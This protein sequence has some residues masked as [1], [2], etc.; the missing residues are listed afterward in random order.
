[1]ESVWLWGGAKYCILLVDRATRKHALY[2][3]W[4]LNHEEIIRALDQYVLDMGSKPDCVVTDFENKILQGRVSAWFRQNGINLRAAP[5]GHQ[6]QNGLV[7]KAWQT[8]C[9]MAHAYITDM[10]MPREY[11]FWALRHAVQVMDYLPVTVNGLTTTP[12]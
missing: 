7:E 12:I 4:S 10:R 9:N 8:A 2:D 11:W 1:M 6:N 5:A 3:L